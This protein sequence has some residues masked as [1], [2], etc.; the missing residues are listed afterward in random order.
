MSKS[1]DYLDGLLNSVMGEKKTETETEMPTKSE[2]DFL[3]EFENEILSDGDQ[4]EFLRQLED[5]MDGK[6]TEQTPAESKIDDKKAFLD[7]LDGI[8]SSVKEKLDEQETE[9]PKPEE[10]QGVETGKEEPGM[11]IMVDTLGDFAGTGLYDDDVQTETE[12]SDAGNNQ[13]VDDIAGDG[14]SMDGL[15]GDSLSMDSLAGDGL[16]LDDFSAEEKP[17]TEEET[18]GETEIPAEDGGDAPKKRNKLKDFFKKMSLVLFGE[19]EDEES[20]EAGKESA[21]GD[22]AEGVQGMSDENL[23][24]LA[25]LGG[26]DTA[27]AAPK[28][29]AE[30]DQPKN[31]KEKKPKKEK[32]KKEKKP[33]QKKEKKPKPPKEPDLTPPLPKGPV[34]LIFVMAASIAAL[35]LLGT[36]LFGYSFQVKEAEEAYVKGDYTASYESIYGLKIKEN[37]QK[38]YQRCLIMANVS[39]EVEAY[40]SFLEEGIYDMA[41]DSLVRAVGRCEK[42]LPDAEEYGCKSELEKLYEQASSDLQAFGISRDDA[43]SLYE[44]S[45]DREAYSTQLYN[46]LTN[47]GYEVAE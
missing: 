6:S 17:N 23:E 27:A 1:E 45:K 8:V 10:P 43:L 34:I 11:D 41:L 13:S 18:S 24:L 47:A 36:N 25:A 32:P 2:E 39:G 46:I 12:S 26:T 21:A 44:N 30:E 40:Q 15:S 28:A 20:L 37:D 38:L 14:L 5:E 33:K 16:S 42:Y 22:V 7:N 3:N 35:V 19:D 31:K 9:E 29:E 4:D